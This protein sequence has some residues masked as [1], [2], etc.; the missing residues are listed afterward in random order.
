LTN[1]DKLVIATL[2]QMDNFRNRTP[3][4]L[5]EYFRILFRATFF[6]RRLADSLTLKFTNATAKNVTTIGQLLFRGLENFDFHER[7]S[8][9][10]CPTL[11]IHG[12]ADSVPLEAV[13]E[14]HRRIKNSHLIILRNTGHFPFIESPAEFFKAVADF[15]GSPARPVTARR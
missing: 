9:I 14:I 3:E 1:S 12:D 15:L 2:T 10:T 8:A 4:A 5:E 6:N 7:L 13:Q 11:I